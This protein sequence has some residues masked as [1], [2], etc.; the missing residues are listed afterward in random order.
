MWHQP[1]AD[2][3]RGMIASGIEAV[4]IKVAALG[5]VPSAAPGQDTARDGATPSQH[6]QVRL[7]P[8]LTLLFC[9]VNQHTAKITTMQ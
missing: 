1:Q 6:V 4:L 7:S 8:G 3:L 2:L 9:S 5:L